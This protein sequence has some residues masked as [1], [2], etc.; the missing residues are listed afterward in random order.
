M[1]SR[2]EFGRLALAGALAPVA[3]AGNCTSFG[4]VQIGIQSYSFW[5]LDTLDQVIAAIARMGFGSVELFSR[6]VEPGIGSVRRRSPAGGVGGP[7]YG[8]PPPGPER[9]ELRNWRLSVSMD[10]FRAIRKKFE[11]AGVSLY[12]YNL[13]FRDDWTD[14]EIVR[15]FE[16]AKALGVDIVSVSATRSVIRRVAPL[17]E[18]HKVTVSI[19]THADFDAPNEIAGPESIRPAL[20]LS[21]FIG[22]NLD[23]GH[24]TA[25]GFDALKMLDEF[26]ARI[27]HLHL[28]DRGTA[29]GPKSPN[30]PWGQGD[31]PI[32]E[33]LLTMRK[34][35]YRFSAM[36]EYE[37]ASQQSSVVEIERCLEYCKGILTA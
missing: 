24:A 18:K 37:Y 25:G 30:V 34:N 13:S 15:G 19:H 8:A 20:A 2:R 17:A 7:P 6:L 36:I 9:D 3:L 31:T 27:T 4:G 33:V 35:H 10:F 23:I 14:D 16:M 5:D 29:Q 1:Q 28:K 21:K 26:H 12:C 22:V 32:K 11:D